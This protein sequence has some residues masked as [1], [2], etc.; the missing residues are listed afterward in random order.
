[1]RLMPMRYSELAGRGG[2]W[3]ASARPMGGL[4]RRGGLVC[5]AADNRGELSWRPQGDRGEGRGPWM[6]Q[7][8]P[9]LPE[10]SFELSNASGQARNDDRSAQCN[11]NEC[12]DRNYRSDVVP[13]SS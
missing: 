2:K 3:A 9:E 10:V 5:A 6:I 12:C 1:V 13:D 4:A 7:I 8:G 11:H